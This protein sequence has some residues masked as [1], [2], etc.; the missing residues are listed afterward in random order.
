MRDTKRER[1]RYRQREKQAPCGEPNAGLDPGTPGSHPKLKADAQPL[2]HPG[3]P[4]PS[5]FLTEISSFCIVWKKY[6]LSFNS[7]PSVF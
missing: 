4:A 7:Y 2:S 5:S 3:I 6:V 1:Q